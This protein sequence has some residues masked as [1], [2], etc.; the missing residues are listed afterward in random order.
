M[1]MSNLKKNR[2]EVLAKLKAAS[3]KQSSGGS[4]SRQTDDR[5][6]RPIFDKER[7]VGSAVIRFLP[8][9]EGEDLPWA[10]VIKHAFKG[11]TG[12][13]YIENSL[14]T[15]DKSDPC[16]LLNARLWNSGVDSDKDQAKAQKQK[17]E[18]YTNVLVI[19][20]PANPENE[21]KVKIYRFG[22]M[23]FGMIQEKMFPK[24]DDD[25]PL[26]P[27]DPW[28]GAN[29]N[30][31]MVAKTVGK[32]T[33]PNYEK[34][35]FSDPAPMCGGADEEIERVYGE[36]YK[37]SEFTDPSVFK[38]EDELK[39][40][41]FDVLGARTGSGVETVEGFAA[42]TAQKAH[43]EAPKTQAKQESIAETATETDGSESDDDLDF[44]KSLVRDL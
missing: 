6:W 8:A 29:F 12:K 18:Y 24:F 26:N 36:A 38:T 11:P 44:L 13:W 16:A 15:I 41:L 25:A 30:I 1:S 42:P 14:R 34:S 27:F 5:Q 21:G 9:V 35:T 40:K 22:P 3:E 28:D 43:Q 2:A 20:D 23:I 4:N 17:I 7:G 33:V 10:K 31:K 37:L 32:D 39:R 19:K